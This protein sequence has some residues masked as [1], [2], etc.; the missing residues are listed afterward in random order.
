MSNEECLNGSL[1]KKV[2]K[3]TGM[4]FV[5]IYIARFLGAGDHHNEIQ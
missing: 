4:D 5:G 1:R 3:G 2:A